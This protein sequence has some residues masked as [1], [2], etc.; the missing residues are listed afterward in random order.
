MEFS[1]EMI[2][3]FVIGGF[4]GFA[5]G[6]LL[7]NWVNEKLRKEILSLK[8]QIVHKNQ[9]IYVYKHYLQATPFNQENDIPPPPA[10]APDTGKRST[11]KFCKGCPQCSSDYDGPEIDEQDTIA[12][13]EILK[14]DTPDLDDV[15]QSIAEYIA[16]LSPE[17]EEVKDLH[18]FRCADPTEFIKR[19]LTQ[20]PEDET[21]KV[22]RSDL[23]Y[24]IDDDNKLSTRV[25]TTGK[26]EVDKFGKAF[27]INDPCQIP[28][29]SS[30]EPS[31]SDDSGSSS[32]GGSDD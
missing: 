12:M 22:S 16:S 7:Y 18:A 11:K 1:L 8:T 21:I 15:H 19:S 3:A 26:P 28:D 20:P 24:S 32:G 10:G 25:E 14:G 23:K 9:L 17:S 13:F 5:C 30:T 27:I 4:I 29:T 6:Q 31:R 2:I